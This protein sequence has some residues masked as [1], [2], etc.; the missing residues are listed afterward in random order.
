MSKRELYDGSVNLVS[1]YQLHKV[2][3]AAA[4]QGRSQKFVLGV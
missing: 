4:I 2:S 3:A 1:R